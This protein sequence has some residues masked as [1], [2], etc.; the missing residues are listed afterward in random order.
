MS[1]KCT[2]ILDSCCDLPYDLLQKEGIYLVNF[3][4]ID[5]KGEHL[6]D[7]YQSITASEF[8]DGMR[9]GEE[10]TTAQVSMP[11]IKEAYQW[12][13]EQ[14]KPCVY[15][16]FSSAL[17]GTYDTAAM[18]LETEKQEHPDMELHLVDTKLASLAEGF[19]V[20]EAI[21]LWEGG[22]TA[23]ELA[24]WALEA[25]FFVDAQFM[26]E[27]LEAL[28]RGGRISPTIAFAGSKLDVKPLLVLDAEGNLGLAG[29]VR[30]RKK[31][32]KALVEYYRKR[33][34]RSSK[35]PNVVMT[36]HS[37]CPKDAERLHE[38]LVQ[39]N[40]SATILDG[41]IGPVIGSH[42]GPGMIAVVFWGS[43]KRKE[44]SV[45]DRIAQKVRGSK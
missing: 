10:P 13:R 33:A 6:D 45:A 28:R 40:E 30:G 38:L 35:W 44:T 42:V 2:L 25:R 4:Y 36:A 9:N 3:P 32:I 12:A 23:Q 22:M 24:D 31:G 37:D 21:R 8:Y 34:D 5:S 11:A 29:V 17:S 20:Y 15:L 16:C 41:Q 1:T 26:L 14:G 39:E 7:M 43:D 27:D 19:L 18:L